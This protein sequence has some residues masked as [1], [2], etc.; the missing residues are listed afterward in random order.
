MSE[1]IILASGSPRRRDLLRMAGIDFE[2]CQCE[3]DETL[4]GK[5][6]EVVMQLAKKKLKQPI[7]F[8]P[9]V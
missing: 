1:T 9:A 2:I 5:P 3:V 7:C 4:S 8:I 6:E